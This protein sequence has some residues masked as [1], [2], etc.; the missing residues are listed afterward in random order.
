MAALL[1]VYN[2]S[3][4]VC[5][6]KRMSEK[7]SQ[8]KKL[9]HT[10]KHH[11]LTI[12]FLGGFVTDFLLLNR[13]DD[14]I[15]NAILTI[16]VILATVSLLLFYAGIALRFGDRFSIKVQKVAGGIMQYAYGGLFSGMLIFYGKSG[17]LV[18]SWPFLVLIIIAIL[19]N[20]LIK[21]RGQQ[22][23]FNLFAYFVGLFSFTVLQV[24]VLTGAM[25]GLVFFL[26]GLIA[27]VAVY[28][29]VQLLT[30]I[31][32]NYL[33]LEMRKIVFTIIGTFVLLQ[34]LYITNIIPPI[35]LSLKEIIIAQSVTKVA[36]DYEIVAEKR[37]WWKFWNFGQINFHPSESNT[38]ACFSRVFAPTK[39]ETKIYHVWYYQDNEQGWVKHFSLE[40]PIVGGSDNGF[41]GYTAISTFKDGKWRCRVETARGQVIGQQVFTIDSTQLPK[42]TSRWVE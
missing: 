39:L 8:I 19:G 38:V 31:I 6:N 3:F 4:S 5:Y 17:S 40:Y 10:I 18:S 27:L 32:P 15:D 14:K 7:E 1:F 33:L 42:N 22:L 12:A 24:P 36:G 11:W 34:A 26:S 2:L 25:G 35:P 28:I 20:E 16:Y 21:N 9:V 23:V 41:R 37:E 13:V 29:V 30:F